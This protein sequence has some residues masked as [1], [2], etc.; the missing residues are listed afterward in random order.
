LTTLARLVPL[1]PNLHRPSYAALSALP[2]RFLSGNAP[3]PINKTLLEAASRL[4]ATLHFTGGKVGAANLWRK[5]LD[6]TLGF[7]WSAFFALR[8]TF[9]TEGQ[10][11]L[12]S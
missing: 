8:S 6:E 10:R 5:A 9:P 12:G 11:D 7:I 2:L 1:Y 3:I 4:Y